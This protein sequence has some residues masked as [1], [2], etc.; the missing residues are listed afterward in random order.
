[1]VFHFLINMQNLQFNHIL[2]YVHRTLQINS[3]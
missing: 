2:M 3:N 1:M